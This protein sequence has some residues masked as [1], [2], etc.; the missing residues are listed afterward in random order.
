MGL[1]VK[2]KKKLEEVASNSGYGQR[3]FEF[4]VD[5]VLGEKTFKHPQIDIIYDVD[6]RELAREITMVDVVP[7]W[8]E[9][10]DLAKALLPY[11]K[12]KVAPQVAENT[13]ENALNQAEAFRLLGE[14]LAG[15]N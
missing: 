6:G 13:D 10:V 11:V 9:R 12:P 3:I 8:E 4:C 15:R 5:V 7:S 2:T 1:D 14:K